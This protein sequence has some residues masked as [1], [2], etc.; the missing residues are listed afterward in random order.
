MQVLPVYYMYP[1]IIDINFDRKIVSEL[2]KQGIKGLAE[3]YANIHRLPVFQN[4][5]AYG[6]SSIPWCLNN[7]KYNTLKEHVLL[8]KVT[9]INKY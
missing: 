6:T 3:G 5:Q 2:K 4:Q 9:M 1:L 8:Q 7:K